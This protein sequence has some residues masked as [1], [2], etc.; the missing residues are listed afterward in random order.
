MLN[1]YSQDGFRC[2]LLLFSKKSMFCNSAEPSCSPGKRV[3][4]EGRFI[5][6]GR[7]I[8][9]AFTLVELLVV[10]AIIGILI[11]LLLPAI[12]AARESARRMSCINH[13]K[14][15]SLGC[16]THESSLKFFPTGGWSWHWMADPD[17]GYGRQQPGSWPY[18]I[19]SYMEY[20]ALHDMAMGQTYTSGQ[21]QKT[22]SL[23]AQTPMEIFNCP[24]RRSV[25]VTVNPCN[26][27]NATSIATAARTDY[28]ANGGEEWTIGG[29]WVLSP[30][31]PKKIPAS[32]YID[33]P[34]KGIIGALS[35]V[36]SKDVIDGLSKTYLLGEK[37][38]DPD[39][40]F[41]GLDNG[42]NQ[43]MFAGYDWDY[44]RWAGKEPVDPYYQPRRDR[45]GAELIIFGSAHP[46]AFNMSFCDGSV[47]SIGYNIDPVIHS[48]LCTR[49]D[50]KPAVLPE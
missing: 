14:Q 6:S 47:Q 5:P 18:N 28:A 3:S 37:Y 50:R 34:N 44:N 25:V 11:A 19:L 41:D 26:C 27:V 29:V 23:M 2:W 17:C 30:T 1:Y 24:T 12:Q 7:C 39:C 8:P 31:D 22:L 16:L 36:R 32:A 9:A 46:A 43:P 38:V 20:K 21:K 40:Y 45:P 48:R 33:V 49:G 10:I 42:D 35:M 13:L 15:L 4:R